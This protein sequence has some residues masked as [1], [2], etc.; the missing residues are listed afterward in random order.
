MK[1]LF[2]VCTE[3]HLLLSLNYIKSLESDENEYIL[4]LRR[5]S[6][7]GRFSS[8]LNFNHFPY[9]V[10]EW[11][12]DFNAKTKLTS[13][14]LADINRIKSIKPDF[15]CFFQEQD[16]LSMLLLNKLDAKSNF[17]FQDGMKAYNRLKRIPVSLLINEINMQK[18]LFTHFKIKDDFFNVFKAHRYGFRKKIT[19]LYLTFPESYS[20]WNKRLVHKIQINTEKYFLDD[21]KQLYNWNSQ[22]LTNTQDAIFYVNQPL[23]EDSHT[24]IYV[25]KE[26]INR[27][28]DT[29][30]YIKIHPNTSKKQIEL[31]NELKTVE[32]IESKIPAEIFILSLEN[33]IILSISSSSLFLNNPKNDYY[34]LRPIFAE[35]IKRLKKYLTKSPSLHIKEIYSIS[36]I[37]KIK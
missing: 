22:I 30:F 29:T 33:S 35:K 34:Y 3:Y 31:Y 2:L 7:G 32:I 26:I 27:F 18:W 12:H 24:E 1:Y 4:V 6:N 17:L 13:E 23:G 9:K 28:P 36:E 37:N 14:I 20:N 21:L 19:D 11:N 25:I 5:K 16:M 15:F 8:N 10:L